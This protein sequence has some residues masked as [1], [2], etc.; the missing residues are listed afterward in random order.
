MERYCTTAWFRMQKD[1]SQCENVHA[2]FQKMVECCFGIA[3]KYWHEVANK[4][5]RHSFANEEKEIGFFKTL[6]PKF[7]S[8]I[9]YYSLVYHCL[10]FQPTDQKQAIDFLVRESKR[11]ERFQQEYA[12]FI[13]CYK[14][15]GCLL[16]GHYFLRKYYVVDK[17]HLKTR[18]HDS[19]PG[20]VT[21]GDPL[22]ATLL[23]FHRYEKF[24]SEK[25]NLLIE[26]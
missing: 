11:I 20:S 19:E 24:L 22:A 4:L 23:A 25:L 21:N 9:E 12:S 13:E 14:T 16:D 26:N 8:E 18:M 15:D 6:K 2:G 5:K 17:N 3:W 1:L 10:L 7:T